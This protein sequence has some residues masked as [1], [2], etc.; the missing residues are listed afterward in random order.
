M[1]CVGN[2]SVVK[3]YII[4]P[5]PGPCSC[6]KCNSKAFRMGIEPASSGLLDQ[7]SYHRVTEAVDHNLGASSVYI[8]MRW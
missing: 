6:E 1:L 2:S 3:I 5:K 8:L 7:C 4:R